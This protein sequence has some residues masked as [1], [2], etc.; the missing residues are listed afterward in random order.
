M[1]ISAITSAGSTACKKVLNSGFMKYCAKQYEKDNVKFITGVAIT[2]IVLKDALGCYMYVTQSLKNKDIPEEKRAFVAA[3]DLA[4]GGLMIGAQLLAYFTISNKKV[5][6]KMF[7]ALFG[8]IL[9]RSFRKGVVD[10]LSKTDTYSEL[11]KKVLNKN[12]FD[13][14]KSAIGALGMFTTLVG[15]TIVAKRMVVPFIATPLA[16][17]LK[18]NHMGG[19][20]GQKQLT[21]Q[22]PQDANRQFMQKKLGNYNIDN[23]RQSK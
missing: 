2:S 15:S 11:G 14:H 9:N 19:K 3:L 23:F 4:N 1:S 21:E 17:Y 12:Y 22:L 10:R 7:N 6:E 16:T 18:E 5:Q 20:K 13:F 8:K